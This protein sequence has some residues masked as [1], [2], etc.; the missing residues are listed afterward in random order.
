MNG[1]EHVGHRL[2]RVVGAEHDDVV[3]RRAGDAGHIRDAEIH[4]DFADQRRRAA[5]DA[6][7]PAAGKRA[8]QAVGVADGNHRRVQRPV[9][10]VAAPVADGIARADA[11]D[12]G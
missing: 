3:A 2:R 4:T 5:V 7:A 11:G 6:H 8:G 1:A 12:E 10:G 9:G